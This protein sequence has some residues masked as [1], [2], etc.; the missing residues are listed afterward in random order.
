MDVISSTEEKN[1]NNK[2]K[3][4]TGSAQCWVEGG[5]NG[6]KIRMIFICGK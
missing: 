4:R 2:R 3:S 1:N 6:C 5:C